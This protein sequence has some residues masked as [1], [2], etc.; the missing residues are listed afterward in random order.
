MSKNDD[1]NDSSKSS[2]PN[3]P[4]GLI[5]SPLLFNPN[6]PIKSELLSFDFSNLDFILAKL[7]QI[8]FNE[9]IK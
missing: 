7:D 5:K 4:N 3:N 2:L 9:E 1:N 6:D 8:D